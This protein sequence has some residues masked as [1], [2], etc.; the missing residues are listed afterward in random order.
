[1]VNN[2][3]KIKKDDHVMVIAGK[4]KGRT[5]KVLKVFPS[6]NKVIVQ[7]ANLVKR[8]QKQTRGQNSEIVQKEAPLHISNV[9][10]YDESNNKAS[11]IGIKFDTDGKKVRYLKLDGTVLKS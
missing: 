1:M 4:D 10:Y 7:G 2:K 6:D 9:K 3:L 8:H 11:K 5:G